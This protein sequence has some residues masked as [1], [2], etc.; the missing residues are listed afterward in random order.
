MTCCHRKISNYDIALITIPII[1][2]AK[3]V[4]CSLAVACQHISLAILNL[5]I[6]RLRIVSRQISNYFSTFCSH[7]ICWYYK[8]SKHYKK[9]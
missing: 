9:Y 4:I 5:L 3:L 6:A 1:D 7:N 2:I 8:A